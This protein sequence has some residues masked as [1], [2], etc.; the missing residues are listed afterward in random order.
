M[1]DCKSS[2]KL[3]KKATAASMTMG[4]VELTQSNTAGISATETYNV[5]RINM[6]AHIK[7]GHKRQVN[8][9]EMLENLKARIN[10]VN[11]RVDDIMGGE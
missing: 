3:G 5:D 10:S 1:S 7:Q 9:I 8:F 6:A 2:S 11:S 4:I